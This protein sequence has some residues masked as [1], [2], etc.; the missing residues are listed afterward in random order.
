MTP[1]PSRPAADVVHDAIS[2]W[3]D[4]AFDQ[5]VSLFHE[6]AEVR[7]AL[8][9]G[10]HG[11]DVF[12]GHEGVRLWMASVADNLEFH[13]EPADLLERPPYVLALAMATGRPQSGGPDVESEWGALF[14][15]TAGRIAFLETHLHHGDALISLGRR[16]KADGS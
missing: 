11:D 4:R 13:V 9:R 14:E 1:A 3:N 6:T 7:S 15:V 10:M 12:R 8:A 16:L 5:L 2:A